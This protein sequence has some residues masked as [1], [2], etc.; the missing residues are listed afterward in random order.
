[1]AIDKIRIFFLG[2]ASIAVPALEALLATDTIELLG[3]GT[4]PDRKAGRGNRLTPTPVGKRAAEL[5]LAPYK[6]DNVN[7]E[8]FLDTLRKLQIDFLLVIAFGQLL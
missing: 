6:I 7:D 2:S 5:E 4:Q 1:M 3:V 8:A